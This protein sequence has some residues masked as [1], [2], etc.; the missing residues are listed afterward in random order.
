M[1]ATVR[2]PLRAGPGFA[3]TPTLTVPLPI[4]PP[5]TIVSHGAF[6]VAVHAQFAVTLIVVVFASA[7]SATDAGAIAK[8]HVGAG[9]AWLTVKVWPAIVT[10]PLRAASALP[11]AAT[12]TVALPVP[13]AAP[14]IVSHGA[15]A[16]ALQA[17]DGADA[18]I[19]TLAVPALAPR[20]ALVGAI[21][22]LHGGGGGGG[23]ADCAIVNVRPATVTAPERSPPALAATVNVTVA[24]PLPLVPVSVIHGTVL[25]AVQAQ[26]PDAAS[27][28]TVPLPP[29]DP[30]LSVEA[31]T[32]N[33]QFNAA[34]VTVNVWP[35]IVSVPLRSAP[36]FAAI[37]NA[38]VPGPL[39]DP[40]DVTE[41]Q[42]AF[43]VAVHAQPAAADTA[44]LPVDTLDPT[45][46][47][48]ESRL[49]VH[50]V[51]DGV[52]VGVGEGVG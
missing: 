21:V 42:L 23:A 50:G 49:Y 29:D 11:A 32:V 44:T 33:V 24:L 39:P 51:G 31:L 47:A 34:C 41:I 19:A 9:A 7:P 48:V 15:L 2:V 25:D 1:P 4:P 35:A 27:M 45:R 20:F 5:L 52:G 6:D 18:V 30:K 28:R 36:E 38:T 12:V 16:V 14:A 37:E 8:L 22:K 26:L 10:V 43:D 46:D 3:A 40:P 13:L 17:H